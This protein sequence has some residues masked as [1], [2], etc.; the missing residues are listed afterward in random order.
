M[1]RKK[2]IIAVAAVVVVVAAAGHYVFRSHIN[3]GEKT[4]Y[5]I[6]DDDDNVDSVVSKVGKDARGLQMSAFEWLARRDAYAEHIRTGRYAIDKSIGALSL[7]QKLKA[8]EKDPLNLTVPSV[9]TLDKMAARLSAKL[10]MDSTALYQ[11]L[12]DSALCAS[13]GCDT[14]NVIGL[15]LPNTYQVYWDVTPKDLIARMKKEHDRF[16]NDERKQKAQKLN[17]SPAEVT[18]LASIVAEETN[19]TPE[20][21]TV[22]GLYLNRIRKNMLLQADPTVKFAL[23]DFA[24]KRVLNRMLA[25][26][27]PYNT[28]KYE[29]LPPGPIRNPAAEDIDAVLEDQRHEYLYMCA[30]ETFD[31][32]HNF[33]RTMAEH[34]Q[35]ARKYTQALNERGI[36]K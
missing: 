2:T 25:V 12:T 30:K 35:N 11:A 23:R 7:Y 5:I 20:K 18:V 24:A 34:E 13:L 15:F 29:G 6:I 31:G 22:A 19:Y 4:R 21:A 33:A 3:G 1:K 28:Y 27:S 8:G 10:Q 17:L 36:K 14:A 9:R 16:W 32:T 26:D